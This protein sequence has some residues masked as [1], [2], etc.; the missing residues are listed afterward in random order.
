MAEDSAVVEVTDESFDQ[1]VRQQDNYC[2]VD[3]YATWCPHCR[4][5]RP[6]LEQVAGDYSGP[7]KFCAFSW[8]CVI[9]FEPSLAWTC[10]S[11]PSRMSVNVTSS[12]GL[13]MRMSTDSC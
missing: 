11:L 2:V 6:T 9:S 1:E 8:A 10:I 13:R 5:F 4:A 12:P 7:V 3:F